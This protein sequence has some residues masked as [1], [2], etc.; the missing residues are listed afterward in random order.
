M[1]ECDVNSRVYTLKPGR[2]FYGLTL[3]MIDLRFY[4][5]API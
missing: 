4:L 2:A 5:H 1:L 3:V